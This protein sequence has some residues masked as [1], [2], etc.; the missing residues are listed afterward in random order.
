M[1]EQHPIGL[2][3]RHLEVSPSGYYDWQRRRLC[4]GPR[5]LADET[6][7]QEIGQIHAGSRQT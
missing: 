2:I 4:P 1:K 6:L 5:A 3:C 7:R